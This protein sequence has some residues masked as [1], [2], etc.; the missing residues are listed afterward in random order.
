[1][2]S[3]LDRRKFQFT[4]QRLTHLAFCVKMIWKLL[5]IVNFWFAIYL[6]L[7]I[8]QTM[9]RSV[10]C[11][12]AVINKN[13]THLFKSE[14]EK[15]LEAKWWCSVVSSLILINLIHQNVRIWDH[16]NA[17]SINSN[18]NHNYVYFSKIVVFFLLSPKL[19]W[20][21]QCLIFCPVCLKSL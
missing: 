2:I 7:L 4:R 1:M 5:P 9:C 20:V 3:S 17:W 18:K 16:K 13:H 12:C 8:I 10:F 11:V 6:K 21:E 14:F 19:H 15:K